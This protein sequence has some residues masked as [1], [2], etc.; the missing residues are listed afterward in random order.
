MALHN[1][2]FNFQ[3]GDLVVCNGYDGVIRE[4]YVAPGQE[5]SI[6]GMYNVRLARGTTCVSGFDLLPRSAK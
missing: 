2:I 3:P 6:G 4:V 1:K 5:G